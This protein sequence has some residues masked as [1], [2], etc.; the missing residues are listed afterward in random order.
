M[1]LDQAVAEAL[2]YAKSHLGLGKLGHYYYQN[3]LLHEL[4][5]PK[6]YEGEIDEE[7]IASLSL[8]D[9][10]IEHLVEALIDEKGMAV[11]EAEREATYVLGLLSPDPDA[12]DKHCHELMSKGEAKKATDYLYSLSIENGYIAKSKVDKNV[13][14]TAD[15]PDG[16]SLEISINLAKP[17]KNNKDIAKLLTFKS[18]GYPKCMLCPEN[19]GYEGNPKH[20]ARENIRYISL[21]LDG[22]PWY[23]QY[24]PYVYYPEHCIVFAQDHTPMVMNRHIFACLLDFLDIFPFYFI[25][26]NSDLPI[27]GGSILD[28]EHFQGGG[29]MLPLLKSKPRREFK[30]GVEGVRLYEADF[31]DTCLVIES[32]DKEKLLDVAEKIDLHWHLYADEENGI[33]PITDDTVFHSTVTPLARKVDKTYKM[34][35]ILRNNRTSEQYPGGIFHA[36]PEYHHIKS[37]GIGLIEAAGLFILPARLIRQAK[38]AEDIVAKGLSKEEALKL[39]PDM[40]GFDPLIEHLRQGKDFHSYL[41]EVARKI[42]G[43]VAVFKGEEGE[44]ALAKFVRRL[45][46]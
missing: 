10:V 15:Y 43:N 42:L 3:L 6:P 1:K 5:L 19:L 35:L 44:K 37:E 25:G 16:P 27:V 11:D 26:S 24:S 45:K 14:F 41:A 4:G 31:Y 22:T 38:Q 7:H 12:V 34:F 17:E 28:H 8:P 20:P 21:T 33:I 39:Y 46:L 2:G 40:E 36:H 29:H 30:I 32:E 23:A 13:F 18:S 9:E